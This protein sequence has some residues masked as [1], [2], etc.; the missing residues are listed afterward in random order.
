MTRIAVPART[1]A[2]WRALLADPERQWRAG[3]SAHALA[4]AW[5][6]VADAPAGLPPEVRAVFADDPALANAEALLV[7]PEHVTPL[8][9]VGAGSPTGALVLARAA[10][11]LAVIAVDGKAGEPFGPTVG[12]WR[13]DASP[14]RA[15]RLAHL[16]AVL[17]L[18]AVSDDICH[19]LLHRTAAALVE[20]DAF[21]ARHAVVLV[22]AFSRAASIPAANKTPAAEPPPTTDGV[23]SLP[24]GFDDYAA[25]VALF[26]AV[27]RSGT[28]RPGTLATVERADG[29]RLHFAWAAGTS[30]PADP[31]SPDDTLRDQLGA[32]LGGPVDGDPSA[33]L[34]YGDPVEVLVRADPHAVHV[35]VPVIEW[36]GHAPVLT[37]ER[38]ASFPREAVTRFGGEAPFI[39]AV[40]AARAER[41]ARFRTCAECGERNPPEWLHSAT[42]CSRCAT[43]R[44]GVTY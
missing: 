9:G 11:G 4:H 7:I 20:A 6:R 31:P 22:H 32:I 19:Q 36:R 28:V 24:A 26:G 8:A 30:A 1:V 23:A 3:R 2:E 25:L 14:G 13:A 16:L 38:R 35:E 40:L 39:E 41:V 21:A 37:G 33:L 43:E 27:T 42:L 17:G 15:E 5:Q 34:T 44:R 10:D 29:R 12:E 18:P